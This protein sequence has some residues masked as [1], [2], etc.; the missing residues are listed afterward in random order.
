[1]ALTPKMPKNPMSLLG[2]DRNVVS[3]EN[4]FWFSFPRREHGVYSKYTTVFRWHQ[5][6]NIRANKNDVPGDSE[7]TTGGEVDVH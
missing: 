4:I 6:N 5:K 1:M 7:I 3:C 2:K